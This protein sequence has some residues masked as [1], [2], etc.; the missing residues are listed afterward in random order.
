MYILD[1]MVRLGKASAQVFTTTNRYF[2]ADRRKYETIRIAENIVLSL[3]L[4]FNSSSV[5]SR[6]QTRSFTAPKDCKVHDGLS[7]TIT[8]N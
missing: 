3:E 8:P 5:S 7:V 1:G 4:F 6:Y 2:S